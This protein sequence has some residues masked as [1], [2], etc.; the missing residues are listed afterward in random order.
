[1]T[2]DNATTGTPGNFICIAF[3]DVKCTATHCA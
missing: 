2:D 1:M 3:Q